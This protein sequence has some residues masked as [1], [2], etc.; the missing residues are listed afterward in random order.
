VPNCR[1]RVQ[2]ETE[3]KMRGDSPKGKDSDQA[4]RPSPDFSH[5]CRQLAALERT[6]HAKGVV[7]QTYEAWRSREQTLLSFR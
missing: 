5:G 7:G 1:I 4:R 2:A 6:N 3:Q